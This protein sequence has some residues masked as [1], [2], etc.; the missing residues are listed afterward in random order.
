MRILVCLLALF[1]PCSLQATVVR[2]APNFSW[3]GIPGTSTLQSVKGQPVV[4]LIAESPKTGAFKKQ[5]KR[6]K[7]IY[8]QYAGRGAIFAA[9]FTVEDGRIESDIPFVTVKDGAKTAAKF[10]VSD[11]YALI[12][13]GKDGNM[14]M[15]TSKVVPASRVRDVLVNSYVVQAGERSKLNQ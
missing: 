4:L 3:A 10:G 11:S 14:D 6:L 13:I 7:E 1:I 15:I 9:A 12:V 5:I 2:P 8:D